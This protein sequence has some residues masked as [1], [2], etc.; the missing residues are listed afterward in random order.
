MPLIFV[1]EGIKVNI[2]HKKLK[3]FYEEGISQII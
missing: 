3:S 2:Q 1:V